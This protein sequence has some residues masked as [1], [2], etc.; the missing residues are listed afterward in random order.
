[1]SAPACDEA[2]DLPQGLGAAFR[3]LFAR[4]SHQLDSGGPSGATDD[5]SA[6]C[7][8][9]TVGIVTAGNM[10]CLLGVSTA[11]YWRKQILKSCV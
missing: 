2:S 1:V 5:N 3:R 6:V 11:R 4:P 8:F 9:Y 7:N 10:A